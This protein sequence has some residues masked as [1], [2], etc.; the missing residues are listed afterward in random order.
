MIPLPLRES[1]SCV[2]I[3]KPNPACEEAPPCAPG[4][5]DRETTV[6]RLADAQSKALLDAAPDAM[7]I[8]D[9]QGRIAFVNTQTERVFGYSR[10]ELRGRPIEVLLPERYRARHLSHR[11]DYFV[12]PRGRRMGEGLELYALRKDGTE[13]PAEVS[14]S[15]VETAD[16]LLVMS[17]IRD[18]SDRK[19]IERELVAAREAAERA[20]RAKSAFLAA[21]SHDLRQPLQTLTLLGRVL[22]RLVPQDS[23]A[24]AAL[25]TQGE[26]LRSMSK[27]LNSLLDISKLEAGIIVPDLKDC[28]VREIFAGL[29]AEF[30]ALAE[31]KGLDL[32]VEDSDAYVHTDPTL[33]GQII[34]NLVGNSIRYTRKGW[35]RLR[36]AAAANAFRI[37][38]LDTGCGIAANELGLIFDEFYQSGRAPG[39]AREGLG[40]GLSIVRRTAELLG[41]RLEVEST[42]GK[43]S[44]FAFCVPAAAAPN[45]EERKPSAGTPSHAPSQG[46]VLVV[47]D[48]AAVGAATAML[49][50]TMGLEVITA[51]DVER[52][53][54][55]LGQRGAPPGLVIAD[56]HLGPGRN[57]LDAIAAVRAAAG[58]AVPAILV[59]GDTS[60]GIAER[61]RGVD[62]CHLLRKPVDADEL[63]SLSERLVQ[64]VGR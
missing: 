17:A 30:A 42:L 12:A 61:L 39:Q 62:D 31:A 23:N 33:L 36:T 34:Q 46:L 55:A 64:A 45:V 2:R 21:A 14:L 11:L 35:V 47:D 10:A 20:D 16:G 32:I 53:E 6:D 1:A 15:P 24:A 8:V 37:E 19:A 41:Y 57:G 28:A 49:L 59:S 29:R 43:G 18:I 40:L 51:T 7:V 50:K 58:Y 63:M 22:N 54:C 5:G 3:C 60:A 38:V 9:A 4:P 26:A 44:C 27:L 52:A 56:Y 25:A 13:F 48:D